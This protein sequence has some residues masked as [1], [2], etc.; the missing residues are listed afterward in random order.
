M[1]VCLTLAVET[2]IL[3]KDTIENTIEG[4]LKYLT[5]VISVM[6]YIF[7]ALML[8]SQSLTTGG[9][10]AFNMNWRCALYFTK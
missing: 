5:A 6:Q 10:D 9:Y 3:V 1:R 8:Q 2:L 7:Q 4:T